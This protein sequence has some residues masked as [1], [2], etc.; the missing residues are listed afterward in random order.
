MKSSI[1]TGELATPT[2]QNF[3]AEKRSLGCA[4]LNADSRTILLE[5][6]S[7]DD[8]FHDV[9]RT[10]FRVLRDLKD[11]TELEFTLCQKLP[12]HTAE[13]SALSDGLH[14]KAN[15]ATYIAPIIEAANRRRIRAAASRALEDT[16]SS[17]AEI[18]QALRNI[19]IKNARGKADPLQ[20]RAWDDLLPLQMIPEGGDDYIVD[21]IINKGGVTM[22]AGE[23]GWYKSWLAQSLA[24]S[25][26]SGKTFLNLRT[27][28]TLVLYLDRENTPRR[29][30]QRASVLGIDLE[31]ARLKFWT[32]LQAPPAL[33][34]PRLIEIARTYAPLIIFDTLI[35]FCP[36]TR[37][38]N[39]S[40]EVA[41][42]LSMVAELTYHG[43][44]VLLL[45]HRP[46]NGAGTWFRGSSDYAAFID[47]GLAIEPID[48]PKGI[49]RLNCEKTRDD[50][51]FSITLQA[52]PYLD[53]IGTF[54]V[55]TDAQQTVQELS[56]EKIIAAVSEKPGINQQELIQRCGLSPKRVRTLLPKLDGK[57]LE[58]RTGTGNEKAIFPREK[59]F[60][61]EHLPCEGQELYSKS[62][63]AQ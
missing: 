17:P 7:D 33:G 43:A 25:V 56:S 41:R 10:V 11:F 51:P 12:E 15:V 5:Q 16:K 2:P 9:H 19:T 20:V 60:A 49:L 1:K 32:K 3:E 31:D 4:I 6:L 8:F 46:K 61:L 29:V 57:Q 45:H 53:Q 22:I 13:I 54:A 44:S 58:I 55:L 62:E 38:E 27:Q 21:R 37:D 40:S 48:K 24:R 47:V 23:P 26:A 14:S 42:A 63:Q 50:E 18:A 28:E 39:S 59:V 30:R 36:G 52:R 35:R 34:D